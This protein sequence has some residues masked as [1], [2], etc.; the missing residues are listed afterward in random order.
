[1]SYTMENGDSLYARIAELEKE[2]EKLKEEMENWLLSNGWKRKD[3]DTDDEDEEDP[4]R[5]VKC[6]RTFDQRKLLNDYDCAK[7]WELHCDMGDDEG[8][9][10]GACLQKWEDDNEEEIREHKEKAEVLEDLTCDQ[11]RDRL[12]AMNKP[13]SGK[14]TKAVLIHVIRQHEIREHK[15]DNE[16][17]DD[18]DEE[19]EEEV[20]EDLTCAQLK[21]R[22]RAINK[23][24]GGR[25]ADLIQRIR[26]HEALTEALFEED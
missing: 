6:D 25:K 13:V 1:M 11:L 17:T 10:C 26:D 2:N 14:M 19:E 3:D 8:D 20:L 12:R 18:E 23:P 16:D 5:C 7:A 21:Q 9:L 22:L 4:D 24:V 15:R